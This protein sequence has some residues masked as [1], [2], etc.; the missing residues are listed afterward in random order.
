MILCPINALRLSVGRRK[1]CPACHRLGV[2]L[3]MSLFSVRCF[4]GFCLLVVLV[5]LSVSV[6][7][8]DW[9]GPSHTVCET[10]SDLGRNLQFS[11]PTVHLTPTL[12]PWDFVMAVGFKKT[13]VML[14]PDRAFVY[15]QCW[16][17]R[18]RALYILI[19][20]LVLG[21]IRYIF[22]CSQ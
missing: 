1:V 19:F 11:Q 21:L 8:T 9:R 10:S 5:R 22:V 18:D 15:I 16:L 6:Y 20:V 14:L 2:G 3:L 12:I 4:L 17:W 7:V 13:S